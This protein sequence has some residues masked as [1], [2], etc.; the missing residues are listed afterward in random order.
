MNYFANELEAKEAVIQAFK[1]IFGSANITIVERNKRNAATREAIFAVEVKKDDEKSIALLNAL[2]K[3]HVENPNGLE[4][5]GTKMDFLNDKEHEY[6]LIRA[7]VQN[8]L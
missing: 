1:P 5:Q 8:S 2:F 7:I 6:V 4:W 3:S